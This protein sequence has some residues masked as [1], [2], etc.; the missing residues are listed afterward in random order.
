MSNNHR[1]KPVA[2]D[3][4]EAFAPVYDDFTANHNFELWLGNL[5]PVIERH[6]PRG[7]RLLDV[8][9]GT[10]RS[11]L[12]MLDRGWKV[13]GCD[14]S[15]RMLAIAR[16][17]AGGRGA[18]LFEADMRDLPRIGQFDLV[19]CLDDALNYMVDHDELTG[20]LAAMRI[21]LAADGLLVFDVNTLKVFRTFFAE[22]IVIERNGVRLVWRGISGKDVPPGGFGEACFHAEVLGDNRKIDHSAHLHRERH[23][24]EPSVLSAMARAGLDCIDVYGH[25]DDAVPEQPLDEG[26]HT[27]AV[28]IG[29]AS[30]R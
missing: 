28:Y 2:K 24:D 9:C 27:K 20:A 15:P 6:R 10:G 30:A 4:Y 17:K 3:A 13:T 1:E 25:D 19:W 16:E 23:F 22:E 18:S 8:G 21:N 7:R 14:I 29:R 5:W 11:F 26:R 12:A